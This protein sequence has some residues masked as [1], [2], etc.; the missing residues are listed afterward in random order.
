[1]D[2]IMAALMAVLVVETRKYAA[3]K[4]MGS[5]PAYDSLAMYN[6]RLLEEGLD[7]GC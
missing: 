5:L 2:I 1:M 3:I 7:L 4:E 6:T